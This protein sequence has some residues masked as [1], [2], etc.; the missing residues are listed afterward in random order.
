MTGH[1]SQG[2]FL[3]DVQ[4]HAVIRKAGGFKERLFDSNPIED[5]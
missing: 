2:K 3:I 4:P 5:K 1:L